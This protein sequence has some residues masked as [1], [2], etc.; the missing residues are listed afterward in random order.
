MDASFALMTGSDAA[1]RKQRFAALLQSH[2]GLLRR[3]AWGFSRSAADRADLMQ[4]MAV[5][6]WAVFPRWDEARPFSTWAY[7]V[8][9]NVAL[10]QARA[11]DDATSHAEPLDDSAELSCAGQ[12]PEHGAEVAGLQRLLQA[13]EPLNR[14]L[15]LL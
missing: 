11:P 3:L 1:A 2:Q 13:L 6:L 15:L 8:A 10:G 9:L 5:Q 14:A 4:D 12:S 7:R